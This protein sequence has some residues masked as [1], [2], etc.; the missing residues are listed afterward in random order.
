M[1]KI[2]WIILIMCF[3]FVGLSFIMDE[4]SN[5]AAW[6]TDEGIS[7]LTDTEYQLDKQITFCTN[8]YPNDIEKAYACT[9]A[10]MEAYQDVA[11]S[12][13]L[14]GSIPDSEMTPDLSQTVKCVGDALTKYWS[15][16]HNTAI[17]VMVQRDAMQCINK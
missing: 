4:S 2:M 16:K 13:S 9:Q 14:L 15:T 10:S 5:A 6:H 8:K 12:I 7:K 17:W 3:V 11:S 1:R